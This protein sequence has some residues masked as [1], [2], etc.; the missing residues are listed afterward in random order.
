MRTHAQDGIFQPC[1]L[2]NLN[3][4]TALSPI[5]SNYRSA[6]ADPHWSAAMCSEYNALVENVTWQLIPKPPG[7]NI[8]SGKWVYCHK[9]HSDG[10]LARYKA[11]WVV[12]GFCQ[13]YGIDYEETFSPVVKPSTIR[14]ILSLAISSSWPIHQLDVKNA[15]LHGHLSEIVY[16]QQPKGFEDPHRPHDVCL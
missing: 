15:F 1:K 10:S 9:F 14:I 6:L 11:R 2:F 7:A 8:V 5:P 4:I 3:T 16:C 13:E 12:R